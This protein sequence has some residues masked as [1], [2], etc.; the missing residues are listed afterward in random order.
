MLLTE[1][2]HS[3]TGAPCENAK[4][5]IALRL[6]HLRGTGVPVLIAR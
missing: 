3:V 5:L 2:S 1:M 4:T 6:A